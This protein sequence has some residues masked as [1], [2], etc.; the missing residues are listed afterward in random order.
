MIRIVHKTGVLSFINQMLSREHGTAPVHLCLSFM[1]CGFTDS[2]LER[3]QP[4]VVVLHRFGALGCG[5]LETHK[6]K[7]KYC[8]LNKG[9]SKLKIFD[10][11]MQVLYLAPPAL[12]VKVIH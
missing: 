11:C 5:S 1:W 9:F 8:G 3:N 2:L 12:V 6:G 7:Y 10:C 4:T